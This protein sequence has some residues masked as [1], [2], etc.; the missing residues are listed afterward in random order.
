MLGPIG[1]FFIEPLDK[2][3]DQEWSNSYTTALR[4]V[5]KES[6]NSRFRK[7]TKKS[8][9]NAK[10]RTL[11]DIPINLPAE[12]VFRRVQLSHLGDTW[13]QVKKPRSLNDGSEFHFSWDGENRS[14]TVNDEAGNAVAGI[15]GFWFAWFAFHPDTEVFKAAES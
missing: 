10:R 2:Y 14:I 9:S 8:S 6:G 12:K 4:I 1:Q 3:G 7:T 11:P 15:Q 13:E 5:K